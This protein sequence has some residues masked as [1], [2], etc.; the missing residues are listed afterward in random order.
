MPSFSLKEYQRKA[1]EQLS[2]FFR[3]ARSMGIAPA[4][5]HAMARQK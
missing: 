5:A 2:E 4:W 3:Q 1:L